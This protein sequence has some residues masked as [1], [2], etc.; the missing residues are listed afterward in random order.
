MGQQPAKQ[1]SRHAQAQESL[2]FH[3]SS[4]R[5]RADRRAGRQR[6]GET[7]DPVRS[8]SVLCRHTCQHTQ[9]RV[10]LCRIRHVKEPQNPR[11]ILGNTVPDSHQQKK[12]SQCSHIPRNAHQRLPANLPQTLFLDPP[13]A[14]NRQNQRG[15]YQVGKSDAHVQPQQ[16][17]GRSQIPA[18][19]PYQAQI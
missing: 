4:R 15:L 14:P 3:G 9:R 19:L 2:Y 16:H 6:Q 18:P 5:R 13:V 7:F 17:P 1:Y 11:R 8:L 10:F 12:R